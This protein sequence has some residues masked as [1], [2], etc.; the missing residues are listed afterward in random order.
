MASPRT[1]PVHLTDEERAV[2][3][4]WTRGRTLAAWR[5]RRARII[6][7]LDGGATIGRAAELVG[8][9]RTTV[10]KWRSR[11]AADRLDGLE[12]APRPGRPR[13]VTDEAVQALVER[14]L[15]S[16]PT[17][18]DRAWSTR[19]AAQASGMSQ[20]MVSRVWRAFGL[21]PQAI[22]SW[23]LSTD[24]EFVDKVRD[25]VGLYM[26]PPAD[27]LVLAVDEKTQIQALDRTAPILPVLPTSP[28]KASHD[29]VRHGTT[30]LFAALDIASGSVIT[31]HHAR[32]T[33]AQFIGFLTTIDKAVPQD[34][35][36]HLVLDNYATH[37]TAKVHTWLLRHPR[38]HLHF[39]PT[40]SSWLNLVERWFAELTCRKLHGSAHRSV[41]EL[42]ADI[43]A[44]I[45]QWNHDPKP[46]IWT[47]TADQILSTLAAYC[48]ILNHTNDQP[49]TSD[50]GH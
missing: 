24:P 9:S 2:L 36:L 17:N 4:G 26:D 11:F 28:A 39:T 38:F 43:Q 16:K 15:H 32:H 31:E 49:E 18:G 22:D 23:K 47:K 40:Y 34:L 14:T 27:A 1:E 41:T 42:K 5:A 19:S 7:E 25:V 48:T 8:C 50:S 44:W 12:D 45:N 46:F 21:K 10:G 30:S 29:Y 35:D 33:A 13:A 20:S 37:K 3:E 6:L